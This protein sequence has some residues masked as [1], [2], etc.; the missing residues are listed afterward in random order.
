[1][2]ETVAQEGFFE[3]LRHRT[4]RIGPGPELV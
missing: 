4:H 2:M 1:M 3:N